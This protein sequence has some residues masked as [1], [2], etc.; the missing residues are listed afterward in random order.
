VFIPHKN[1]K[2]KKVLIALDYDPTAKNVAESGFSLADSMGAETFLLHV[3]SEPVHYSGLAYS[4]ILGFRGYFEMSPIQLNSIESLKIAS[5]HYLENIKQQLGNKNIYT[6]VREGEFAETIIDTAK[7][8]KVDVIVMGSHSRKWLE[9]I[10]IGSVTEK[11]LRKT[12]LPVFIVP[13]KAKK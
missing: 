4:P 7:E 5:D 2:M 11:V 13:T 1:E 12:S 10:L 8:K 9:E 3:L 6:L